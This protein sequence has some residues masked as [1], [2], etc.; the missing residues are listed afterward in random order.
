MKRESI[1]AALIVAVL[2]LFALGIALYATRGSTVKRSLVYEVD[3]KI[4]RADVDGSNP[5]QVGTGSDPVISPDGRLVAFT[6]GGL[7]ATSQCRSRPYQTP[8]CPRTVF[9]DALFTM[10]ADGG[11]A[12]QIGW[13]D[14]S[15][16][17]LVW[18]PDSRHLA[19]KACDLYLFDLRTGKRTLV[20]KE[21]SNLSPGSIPS[22]SPDS[23]LLAYTAESSS[24]LSDPL[25]D[26]YVASLNGKS[27]QITHH[28]NAES[29][30]WGPKEI[31]V[32][33]ND[34]VW[35]SDGNGNYVAVCHNH[36]SALCDDDVWFVDSDGKHL[37]LA[38][39][40]LGAPVA[41]SANGKLLLTGTS[42]RSLG[43]P[44]TF[45]ATEFP[46]V[47]TRLS[48]YGYPLAVSRE[49]RV[50]LISTC[51]RGPGMMIGG[52]ETVSFAKGIVRRTVLPHSCSASWNR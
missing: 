40:G 38:G 45:K 41:W 2:G 32:G 34:E 51:E 13:I 42:E 33:R 22:F 23:R 5:K 37:R 35:V 50:A 4:W 25:S 19:V 16:A 28:F 12:R 39:E 8:I 30:V 43:A 1:R 36:N 44:S 6:R 31:A 14:C 52:V 21:D 20:A 27:R 10:P 46:R 29:P 48:G 49:G 47:E 17:N 7:P 11:D 9:T 3:G 18:A 24:G 15:P 26:L